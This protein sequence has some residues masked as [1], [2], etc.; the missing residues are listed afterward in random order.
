MCA[1]ARAASAEM[2]LLL[3]HHNSWCACMRWTNVRQDC[4]CDARTMTGSTDE[5][6]LCERLSAFKL[7]PGRL[8]EPHNVW[9]ATDSVSFHSFLLTRAVTVGPGYVFRETPLAPDDPLPI[10]CFQVMTAKA[11]AAL[12]IGVTDEDVKGID[13]DALPSHPLTLNTQT[14][15]RV[16]LVVELRVRQGDKVRV[17][18]SSSI[19]TIEGGTGISHTVILPRDRV[20]YPFLVLTP[21]AS[22]VRLLHSDMTPIVDISP[23]PSLP[24]NSSSAAGGDGSSIIC[25][26]CMDKERSFMCSP[27]NHVVFCGDC[28]DAHEKEAKRRGRREEL[29]PVCRAVVLSIQRIFW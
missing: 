28:A 16:W 19:L 26:L 23:G 10:I 17:D 22:C 14:G 20:M 6:L 1:E 12:Y 21:T 9:P 18:R 4:C 15:H 7:S 24:H 29:C 11:A 5:A 3:L 13:V 8:V 2:L 27:C 25:F